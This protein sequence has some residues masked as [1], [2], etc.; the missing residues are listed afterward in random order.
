MSETDNYELNDSS[1]IVQNWVDAGNTLADALTT[2]FESCEAMAALQSQN[3][4]DTQQLALHVD[5][6]FEAFHPDL[7]R[8]LGWSQAILAQQRNKTLSRFYKL[9]NEVVR[10]IFMDVVYAPAPDDSECPP[11]AKALEIMCSRLTNLLAVCSSWRNLGLS[12]SELWSFIPMGSDSKA[13]PSPYTTLYFLERARAESLRNRP[14]HLVVSPLL[15]D[16]VHAPLLKDQRLPTFTSVNI[17]GSEH[18]IEELL[19]AFFQHQPHGVLSDLSICKAREPHDKRE[20][21]RPPPPSHS[22]IFGLE[23]NRFTDCIGSL[24]TFRVRGINI[25]WHDV[26]FSNKL[27]QLH[28]QSVCLGYCSDMYKFLRVL[29][30]A[31]ELQH[32][33]II[34][35]LVFPEQVVLADPLA[36]VYSFPKLRTLLLEDL[37]FHALSVFVHSIERGSHHL[38]LFLTPKYRMAYRPNRN[39]IE[40]A[41]PVVYQL[42]EKSRADTLLLQGYREQTMWLSAVEL[43]RTLQSLHSL[44]TLRIADWI[45]DAGDLLALERTEHESP[46]ADSSRFPRL[47]HLDL[48]S[49]G[50][51]ESELGLLLRVVASHP[52][53]SL[54]IDDINGDVTLPW[55]D[56]TIHLQPTLERFRKM[57]PPLQIVRSSSEIADF[58]Q[59]VWQLW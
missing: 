59:N 50:I 52:L 13:H 21:N 56:S 18:Q 33:K 19:R 28:L 20:H 2:Y 16:S 40:L 14:L 54:D 34:S 23:H 36:K 47:R 15:G 45:F 53:E 10:L 42:L 55:P 39:A 9:P 6:S 58:N 51:V 26:T 48:I 32:L 30:S 1:A 57:F 49:Y 8:N 24:S 11:M 29:Q 37:D 35:V 3:N 12:L 4:P 5:S 41:M 25:K 38:T 43:R 17:E 31:P 22:T 46:D 7:S 44:T 27:V